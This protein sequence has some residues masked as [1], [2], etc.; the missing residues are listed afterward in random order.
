MR[1]SSSPQDGAWG[2]LVQLLAGWTAGTADAGLRRAR[3]ARAECER[4]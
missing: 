1:T 4:E 3:A 2:G